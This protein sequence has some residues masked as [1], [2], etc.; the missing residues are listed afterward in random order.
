MR[1][2]SSTSILKSTWR[3]FRGR[4]S[5]SWIRNP[6]LSAP[7]QVPTPLLFVSAKVWDAD[8]YNGVSALITALSAKG[9]ACLHCDLS[10]APQLHLNSTEIMSHFVS[11]LKS[12]GADSG[13]LAFPPVIFAR[14]SAAI[15]AQA[16]ISSNPAT[17]LV[18]TGNIPA[19]NADVPENLL[20]TP[21]EEFNF[22][23]KFPIALVTTPH[24]MER[25]RK[26]NRLAQDP[27]VD[28][29]T[30]EDLASQDAFLK[31][32]GWLDDLGI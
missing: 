1:L 24:E 8:S 23:P 18:L 29:L 15:I 25:L 28:L 6:P 9:F 19:V 31:I 22:E 21:L 16:Y 26:T 12:L 10:T 20:P 3:F 5:S 32:E 14:S 17:A 30:T 2:A 13:I 7:R 27:T 4:W 11:T